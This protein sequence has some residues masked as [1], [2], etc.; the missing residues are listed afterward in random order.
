MSLGN[1]FISGV[2]GP[3]TMKFAREMGLW[4]LIP[5]KLLWSGY[6]G[7]SCHGDHITFS[8]LYY[9]SYWFWATV[10]RTWGKSEDEISKCGLPWKQPVAIATK[11]KHNLTSFGCLNHIWRLLLKVYLCY[12]VLHTVTRALVINIFVLSMNPMSRGWR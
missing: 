10:Q 3:I 12:S 7:N 4:T 9:D 2:Y 6:L 11:N 5:G 8:E 1:V